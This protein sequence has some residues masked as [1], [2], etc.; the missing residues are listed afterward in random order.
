MALVKAS[1]T[2]G[3]VTTRI[4]SRADDRAGCPCGGVFRISMKLYWEIIIK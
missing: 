3:I 2:P 4:G 1:A